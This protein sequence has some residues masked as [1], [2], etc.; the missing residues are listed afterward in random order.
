[1]RHVVAF[2]CKDGQTAVLTVDGPEENVRELADAINTTQVQ[3]QRV[4][5][6]CARE[7]VIERQFRVKRRNG[8]FV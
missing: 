6:A 5:P 1:M 2:P 8:G 7:Y 3:T 4:M